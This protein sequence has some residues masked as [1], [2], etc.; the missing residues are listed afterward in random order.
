[1]PA[2]PPKHADRD[3][4]AGALF[5]GPTGWATA[6][7]ALHWQDLLAGEWGRDSFEGLL[8]A[9]LPAG[10]IAGAAGATALE[11][12]AARRLAPWPSLAV[13]FGGALAGGALAAPAA[14][15]AVRLLVWAGHGWLVG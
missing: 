3:H 12:F 13:S 5:G 6:T 11:R 4:I 1:M 10:L 14:L 2:D 7:A 15:G 8:A 9:A